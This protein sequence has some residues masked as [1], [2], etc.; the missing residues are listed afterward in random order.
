MIFHRVCSIRAKSR[1]S[2]YFF[3]CF[4]VIAAQTGHYL[5]MN[6]WHRPHAPFL[7]FYLA[8]TAAA[9]FGG[10][11]PGLLAVALS[12]LFSIYHFIELRGWPEG[13]EAVPT[14][15]FI[16][17]GV[18]ISFLFEALER[19]DAAMRLAN[20]RKD[21]F[22]ATLA[23]ELRNPLAPI[24]NAV[25]ILRT[26]TD[27]AVRRKVLGIVDNQVRQMTQLVDDLLD[28][29]RI[30]QD[31][32][33]LRRKPVPLADAISAAADSVQP[34]M[35]EKKHALQI[36]LPLQ[37]V[38]LDGD[39]TR[40][41]QIF[42]NILNNAAKYTPPGG[43]IRVDASAQGRRAKIVITD[44]GI[45]IAPEMLPCIFDMFTQAEGPSGVRDGGMGIGLALVR[46]LIRLHGGS[47]TARSKG[48]G[49]GSRFTI[50]LHTTEGPMAAAIPVSQPQ[51]DA[52]HRRIL[53]V[54]DNVDSAQTLAWMLELQGYAVK[55]ARNGPAALEIAESFLPETILLDISMP[56]MDGYQVCDALRRMPALKN[57]VIIAQTGYGQRED[58]QRSLNAGFDAHLVK[59]V[60]ME[61]L[62]AVLDA[63]ARTSP[64][65]PPPG[66][67]EGP[68]IH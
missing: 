31:K 23:H 68:V 37:P 18:V 13:F 56:G 38:W 34:L 1:W 46:K 7:L 14:V 53:V 2:A 64:S 24:S 61:T 28:V 10:L 51:A 26:A 22:L 57:T 49:K 63:R 58:R 42:A 52:D 54:D 47:I 30:A 59:P 21:E 67:I 12:T 36:S 62:H 32:I 20:R 55:M 45:G 9:W 41:T 16:M 27:E 40:L 65:V 35:T 11:G 5:F 60:S 50:R 39:P 17:T 48:L 15:L 33:V 29:A 19:A 3:A 4:I 8:I 44:N 66:S 43:S 6:H 25:E